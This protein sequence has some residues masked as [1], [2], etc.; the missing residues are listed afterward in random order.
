MP[1]ER[2]HGAA[3]AATRFTV[4]AAR[5]LFQIPLEFGSFPPPPR[6]LWPARLS[7][8]VPIRSLSMPPSMLERPRNAVED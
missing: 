8:H 5:A 2:N 3:A 6:S 4:F 7:S 1:V